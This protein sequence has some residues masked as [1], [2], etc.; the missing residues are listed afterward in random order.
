MQPTNFLYLFQLL[1]DV[2]DIF[3]NTYVNCS[4]FYYTL[5]TEGGVNVGLLLRPAITLAL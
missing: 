3:L 5:A 2:L 4:S 1:L